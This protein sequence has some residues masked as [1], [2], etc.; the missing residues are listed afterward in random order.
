[1]ATGIDVSINEAEKLYKN[2][3]KIV[4]LNGLTDTAN[5]KGS[6]DDEPL[7]FETLEM[8]DNG[9]SGGERVS[10]DQDLIQYAE[11]IES[12][13]ENRGPDIGQVLDDIESK[14]KTKRC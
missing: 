6:D 4:Q 11:K 1:V 14:N 3:E 9:S 7:L 5:T 12:K 2:D 13:L 10:V 8:K